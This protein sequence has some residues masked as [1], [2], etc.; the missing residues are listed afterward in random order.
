LPDDLVLWRE[1]LFRH[2]LIIQVWLWPGNCLD[3]ADEQG[4][5]AMCP[6]GFGGRDLSIQVVADALGQ[7]MVIKS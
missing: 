1:T 2:H 5:I 6:E 4:Y 3:F 7:S